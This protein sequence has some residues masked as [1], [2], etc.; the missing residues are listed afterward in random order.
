MRLALGGVGTKPW[1]ARRAEAALVGLPANEVSFQRAA[2]AELQGAVVRE[3]N[4]F[5]V[6]MARR[7][8][9]RGLVQSQKGTQS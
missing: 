2:V 1:R 8:I 4:A 5:K 6:E 9:V 7:A 3:Y